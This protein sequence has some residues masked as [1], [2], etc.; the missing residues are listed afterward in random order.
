RMLVEPE[1]L[2]FGDAK[3]F[4]QYALRVVSLKNP[5]FQ[6]RFH[7]S[8]AFE[9]R[10]LRRLEKLLWPRKQRLPRAQQLQFVAKFIVGARAGEFRGLKFTSGQI[11]EGEADGCARSMSCNRREKIILARVQKRDVRRRTRGDHPH[12]FAAHELLTRSGLLHLIANRNF[13]P[14]ADQARDV[15]LRGVVGNAAH[16]NGIA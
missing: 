4:A 16:R 13:E 8:D 15:A 11:N 14:A 6:A 2:E 5:V 12:D 1:A 7:A 10:S 9:E 3:L